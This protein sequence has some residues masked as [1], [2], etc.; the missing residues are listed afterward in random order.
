MDTG[1]QAMPC[2]EAMALVHPGRARLLAW[3]GSNELPNLRLLLFF[4]I[5]VVVIIVVVSED[6][7]NR[8]G[9]FEWDFDDFNAEIHGIADDEAEAT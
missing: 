9:H 6:I 7:D 8:L 1:S 2:Q 3:L 4:L 5:L